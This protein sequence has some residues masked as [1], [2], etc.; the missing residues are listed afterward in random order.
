MPY[1]GLKDCKEVE[2][3][4]HD[5][6]PHSSDEFLLNTAS[7]CIASREGWATLPAEVRSE[8]QPS[9]SH[10]VVDVR[11]HVFVKFDIKL[12]AG[13]LKHLVSLQLVGCVNQRNKGPTCR[14][15]PPSRLP[16]ISDL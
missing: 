14:V 10:T 12:S 8:S 13:V 3:V 16:E 15:S 9:D 11:V 5:C 2:Q 6:K 7:L 1:L 4:R